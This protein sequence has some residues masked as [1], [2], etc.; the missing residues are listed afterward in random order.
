MWLRSGPA[1][2]EPTS[3]VSRAQHVAL[4]WIS[5]S[6]D[7]PGSWSELTDLDWSRFRLV[8]GAGGTSGAAFI[9]GVL[10]ALAT[11]HDVDLAN[12]SHL[13][14]TSAGSVVATLISMGLGGD[15]LAAVVAGTPQWLSPIGGSYD[16]KFGDE[17]PK[18]PKLRNLMRPMGPRDLARSA[19]LA[20]SRRYRALWL[21][22]LRPGTFDLT[23]QLPFIPGLAWPSKGMLSI[24]CTDAGTGRRVVYD[25][26]SAVGLTDA[27][28]ASW[29]VPA[30]MRPVRIDDRVLV[31]GGV[32]S[33]SNAD[34]A[35]DDGESTL[36]VVVSPMSGTGAHSAVGRASS[37]FASSRLTSEL[38]RSDT[39]GG[40]LVI[41][42]AV[43]LGALVIDDALDNT[44]TTRILGSSFLSPA[45]AKITRRT[46]CTGVP[47]D[48]V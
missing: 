31:D 41:E 14:G 40:V 2:G 8:L 38:R 45:T 33:P 16:L 47:P 28:A 44:T 21:H 4:T 17:L 46:R 19:G 6:D 10:L 3:R 18:V 30:I 25:R 9:A 35:L 48:D 7:G 26:D 22:C 29:A 12:A 39:S 42:P 5:T 1:A 32:V 20:A 37:R 43:S 27:V 13:V 36:T 11:D 24:C 34:I 23:Q 15:D